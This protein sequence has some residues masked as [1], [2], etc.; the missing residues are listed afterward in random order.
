MTC[1]PQSVQHQPGCHQICREGPP[2]GKVHTERRQ[3][4]SEDRLYTLY[5]IQALTTGLWVKIVGPTHS[6]GRPH[7][8]ID[9]L[10]YQSYDG[11]E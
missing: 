6:T 7:L 8:N 3:K 5:R 11:V 1:S 2:S 4:H 9:S 10:R